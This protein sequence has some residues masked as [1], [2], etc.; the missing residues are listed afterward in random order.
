MSKPYSF[1]HGGFLK[2]NKHAV[3]IVMI[4][5]LVVLF[6]IYMS[7]GSSSTD[8]CGCGVHESIQYAKRVP[9]K[10]G[11]KATYSVESPALKAMFESKKE[12]LSNQFNVM[13]TKPTMKAIP[14][15]AREGFS[16]DFIP[17]Q[18]MRSTGEYAQSPFFGPIN[19]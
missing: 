3:C 5:I 1:T 12:G 8:L 14:T 18:V 9:A 15:K 13:K 4:L 11:I 17:P 10:E 2:R 7:W 6:L 16:N 19:L